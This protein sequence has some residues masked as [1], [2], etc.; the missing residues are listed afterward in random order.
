M[1]HLFVME[2]GVFLEMVLKKTDLR[3]SWKA[4]KNKEVFSIIFI[5]FYKFTNRWMLLD[6]N[7]L[8]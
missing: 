3:N 7:L 8:V 2:N 6:L 4:I 5:K 1:W